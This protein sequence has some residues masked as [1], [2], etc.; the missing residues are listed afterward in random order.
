MIILSNTRELCN[1]HHLAL[2]VL[3]VPTDSAYSIYSRNKKRI[4]FLCTTLIRVSDDVSILWCTSAIMHIYN[5]RPIAGARRPFICTAKRTCRV[6]ALSIGSKYSR[7][8]TPFT[9]DYEQCKHTH[10]HTFTY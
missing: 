6:V 5:I 9:D 10:T 7:D 3:Y 1:Q 8:Q 4:V 2:C